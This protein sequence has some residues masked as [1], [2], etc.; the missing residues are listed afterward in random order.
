MSSSIPK[1]AA[2]LFA[3]ALLVPGMFVI[4]EL[5]TASAAS[6]DVPDIGRVSVS[7]TDILVDGVKPD[8]PFFGV[9]DT[10]A[11]AFAIDNYINGN[12]GV[13]GWSSVF[14][15]PDTGA[16]MPVTPNNTPDEFWNQYFAQ[17]A[18]YDV[19]LVRI[20]PHDIWGTGLSYNAW[21]NHREQ[22][23]DLLHSMSYYAQYHGV[24]LC[25]CMG[26]SQEFPAFNFGG[27]G[28]VF[29]PGSQAYN[30]Y[31]TY[32]N[33]VMVE[34]E[35]W[36]SIAMYDVFNE[37][38]HNKVHAA[39]WNSNGG[40]VAFN[41]WANAIAD[42][43]AGVSTHPRNMGVAGFGNMFGMNQ[44]DFNL[45]TGDTRFE[46]LHRHY[47]G[48]NSDPYNFEAPEQWAR[49]KGKPM[50]W[51][52]L[53]NNGPYPLVRYDFAEKAIFAAGGQAITSMVMTGTPGY[54][55]HGGVSSDAPV[56]RP[57][58]KPEP[59][60]EPVPELNITSTPP[61][62][63]YGE[64][65]RYEV[66]TSTPATISVDTDAE[67][68]SLDGNVVSGT[69]DV[70]GS[71]DVSITATANGKVAYQNYTLLVT[72]E[73]NE[74]SLSIV[75]TELEPGKYRFDYESDLPSSE[76]AAVQW[77]FDDGNSSNEASPVHTFEAGEH[78]ILLSLNATDG[79]VYYGSY[80]FDVEQSYVEPQNV[81]DDGKPYVPVA[82]AVQSSG[83]VD[84][85]LIAAGIV[86]GSAI[87]LFG[88]V[89]WRKKSQR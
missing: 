70:G 31:I 15:G 27:S 59:Q 83:A 89:V 45:A 88:F 23:F 5:P 84:P 58:D 29:V 4:S 53:A 1:L 74:V 28:N 54:P 8:E 75:A 11:L 67:F 87:C 73:P 9:C 24:W 50:L 40:K 32:V 20:G 55:Y 69:P 3:F 17:M 22:F 86:Y 61:S 60:P 39:W 49:E 13:A 78:T 34:L 12:R 38:D 41:N 42:D 46:I 10:T 6:P 48:S 62:A 71:F 85:S 47:Y 26:G 82:G 19:N 14:N 80:V 77:T 64:E 7:G 76:V 79:M 30:N 44:A 35:N 33:D 68:L 65:Y 63:T 16:R 81:T 43:T 18:S 25:F 51:G 57:I 72:G 21:L 36:D 56:P 37:P 52:E 66:T 2:A